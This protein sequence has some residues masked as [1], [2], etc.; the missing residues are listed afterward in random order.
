MAVLHHHGACARH[1]F[2]S[3]GLGSLSLGLLVAGFPVWVRLLGQYPV[4]VRLVGQYP[5]R[6]RL[7]GQ[8]P[9]RIHLV[10]G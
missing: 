8:Y 9:V 3:Q 4:W 1:G 5:V 2:Q 10:G 6:V 7:V